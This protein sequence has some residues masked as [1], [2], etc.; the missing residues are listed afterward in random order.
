MV[1]LCAQKEV[2]HQHRDGCGGDD[3][4]SE[5]EEEETKH[6]VY[7]G[8]P[9]GVH[10]EVEFNKDGAKGENAC[11][12]HGWKRS[13]ISTSGRYLARDLVCANW[14]LDRGL[15]E[16]KPAAGNAERNGYD[17][18]DDNDDEH[19]G[20]RYRPRS[21]ATPHEQVEEEEYREYKARERERRADEAKLPRFAVEEFVCAS[22]DVPTNK[23]EESVEDDN[24]CSEGAAVARREETE[25]SECCA[26]VSVMSPN[27]IYHDLPIV[28]AVMAN[29]CAPLP[30]RTDNSRGFFGDLKTSPWT[31][32]QPE[33]SATPS[34]TSPFSPK[35][36]S[37]N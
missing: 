3:H 17:K 12:S 5:A 23:A 35:S 27:S 2:D 4:E 37:A 19:S 10:D 15:L 18:P 6:V 31:S 11:Q 33:S 21:A 1:V 30:T 32:F 14:G 22:R 26:H 36:S 24:D 25:K 28:K 34:S 7:F 20:E 8:E 13:E 29:N 16:T 9:D